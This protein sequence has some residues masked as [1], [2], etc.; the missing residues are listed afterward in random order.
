MAVTGDAVEERDA[1]GCPAPRDGSSSL[2]P[3]GRS[4]VNEILV[5]QGFNKKRPLAAQSEPALAARPPSALPQRQFTQRHSAP[6]RSARS[7]ASVDV[8]STGFMTVTLSGRSSAHSSPVRDPIYGGR[9]PRHA[10]AIPSLCTGDQ[11]AQPASLAGPCM[12]PLPADCGG[13]AVDAWQQS[14]ADGN[15]KGAL[16]PETRRF[17]L[18]SAV[19]PHMSTCVY[20]FRVY[21]HCMRGT[22][23]PCRAAH[24][25]AGTNR[26]LRGSRERR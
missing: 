14:G 16:S 20:S 18:I 25:P 9:P 2:V 5:Q 3:T 23:W 12:P 21:R 15:R 11:L 13:P 1:V 17:F 22:A 10:A 4:H 19:F 7:R 26:G 6:R 8:G 24:W